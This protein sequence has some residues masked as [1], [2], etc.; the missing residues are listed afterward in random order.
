MK[1]GK[2]EP[3][4]VCVWGHQSARSVCGCVITKVLPQHGAARSLP[5]IESLLRRYSL[6]LKE[7]L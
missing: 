4:L 1:L 7:E 5:L 6:W 3:V 2:R